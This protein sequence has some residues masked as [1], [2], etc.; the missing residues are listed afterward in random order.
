MSYLDPREAFEQFKR[1][2]FDAISAQFP[3]EGR[4]RRLELKGL[5]LGK[6]LDADDLGSQHRAKV[7]GDLFRAW[8][9]RDARLPIRR[10]PRELRN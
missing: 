7:S 6:D 9:R 10:A 2:A 5:E 4:T 1:G 8:K 3:I